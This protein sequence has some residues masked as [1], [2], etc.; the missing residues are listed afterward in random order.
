[1]IRRKAEK[2]SAVNVGYFLLKRKNAAEGE[3]KS[4]EGGAEAT[5]SQGKELGPDHHN[6]GIFPDP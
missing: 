5:H 3:D 4:S 2:Q 1:M 6:Q